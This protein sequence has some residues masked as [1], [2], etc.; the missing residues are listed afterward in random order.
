MGP[1]Q[2]HAFRQH[3]KAAAFCGGIAD[4]PLGSLQ[5]G[6]WLPSLHQHLGHTDSYFRSC[7]QQTILANRAAMSGG[8]VSVAD[9]A[10]SCDAGAP[11]IVE[12]AS[13]DE[14]ED[15]KTWATVARV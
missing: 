2:V 11:P 6:R 15:L 4:E 10:N 7:H 5:I 14:H 12:R 8:E 1:A 9:H 3:D 13:F